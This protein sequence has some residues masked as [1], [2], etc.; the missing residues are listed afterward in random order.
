VTGH[1]RV[2]KTK[3]NAVIPK[4]HHLLSVGARGWRWFF[5]T[6]KTHCGAAAAGKLDCPWEIELVGAGGDLRTM[7]PIE[8]AWLMT[9][10]RGRPIV[11]RLGRRRKF[12]RPSLEW[13]RCAAGRSSNAWGAL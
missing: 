4:K 3:E 7:N 12:R 5:V 10:V 6:A 13:R 11:E 8:E 9:Q 2:G 1:F